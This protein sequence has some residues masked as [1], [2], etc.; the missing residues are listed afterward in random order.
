[1]DVEVVSPRQLPLLRGLLRTHYLEMGAMLSRPVPRIDDRLRRLDAYQA[2]RTRVPCLFVR[3]DLPV[4]FALVHRDATDAPQTHE[5]V[6]FAV[7][8]QHRR[9][10]IGAAALSAMLQRWPGRW[11]W[12]CHAHNRTA[13]AFWNT[14]TRQHAAQTSRCAAARDE[15]DAHVDYEI[16]VDRR[17][18]TSA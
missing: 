4:G 13:L 5:I 3:D 14:Q 9:R 2:S 12:R 11:R 16:W 1:M 6:E 15:K 10:G 17:R 8:A 18:G 7:A